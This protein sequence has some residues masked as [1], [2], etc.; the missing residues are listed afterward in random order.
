MADRYVLVTGA[1][2]GIGAGVARRSAELGA[3]IGVA[4]V[5]ATGAE[6]IAQAI[7]NDGGAAEAFVVDVS[8][9]DSVASMF[10]RIRATWPQLD[11]LVCSAGIVIGSP[12]VEMAVEDWDRIF[13]V[14][15][16]GVFL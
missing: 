7:R 9:A 13:A 8:D 14:N 5:N 11:H 4:D 10:G 3:T 2:S 15:T 6:S 12:L 1:A 16:R